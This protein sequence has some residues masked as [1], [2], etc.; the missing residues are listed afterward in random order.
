MLRGGQHSE[1]DPCACYRVYLYVYKI[2]ALGEQGNT[3]TLLHY[4]MPL[5]KSR[6]LFG[7][8]SGCLLIPLPTCS[9]STTLRM[10]VLAPSSQ[11][12]SLTKVVETQIGRPNRRKNQP[13][14][15][16][17]IHETLGIN[18]DSSVYVVS[19]KPSF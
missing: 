16:S 15:S 5:D 10:A 19:L 3:G 2:R 11:A 14:M 7:C 17:S 12:S 18:T 4:R 13:D 9:C 8:L 1:T 6:Q